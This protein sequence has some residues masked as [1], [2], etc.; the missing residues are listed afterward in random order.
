MGAEKTPSDEHVTTVERL[1]LCSSGTAYRL[2]TIKGLQTPCSP[3]IGAAVSNLLGFG[4]QGTDD[5]FKD[6]FFFSAMGTA[7][8]LGGHIPPANKEGK[9]AEALSK[10]RKSV[11]WWKPS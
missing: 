5:P 4:L 1:V 7:L 11:L 8:I 9:Q 2:K 3:Y 10:H 6:P